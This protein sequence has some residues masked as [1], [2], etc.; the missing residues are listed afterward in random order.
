MKYELDNWE[1]EGGAVP[2]FEHDESSVA[3]SALNKLIADVTEDA[4]E[5]DSPEVFA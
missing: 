1:N 4:R 3:E 5:E 2:S